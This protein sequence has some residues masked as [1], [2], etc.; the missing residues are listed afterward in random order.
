MKIEDQI[1]VDR[2]ERYLMEEPMKKLR[3]EI[4]ELLSSTKQEQWQDL[5]DRMQHNLSFGTAGLRGKMEAGYNRMNLVSVFRFSYALIQDLSAHNKNVSVVIGYDARQNSRAF[6]DEASLVFTS[7]GIAVH[8]FS[9]CMP[10][11]L[12]AY[13]TKRLNAAAGVMIT[14]SHNPVYD[15]GIKVFEHTSAQATGGLLRR[16]EANMAEVPLRSDFHRT[17]SG[18]TLLKPKVIGDEIVDGYM[19]DI[20]ETRFF[21]EKILSRDVKVAY[22]PLHGVGKKLFL[23]ALL[24][25]GFDNVMVVKEQSEP[26]GSFSTVQFPNPEEENT[27]N[28]A[29]RLAYE[30]ACDLVIANDPDADRLQV[31][32]PDSSGQMKKLSGNEIGSILGYFSILRAKEMGIR[33]LLASSIVSSRMLK[34]MCKAMNAQYIDALTGFSNIVS[35]IQNT[36]F[37]PEHRF[38]FGYEEALGFLMGLIVLDKDGIHAGVRFMEIAGL[39]KSAKKTIWQL[40]DDLYLKF[41][42]FINTSWSWRF[43]GTHSMDLMKSV[44]AKV[45]NIELFRVAQLLDQSEC[46]KFDLLDEQKG[47]YEGLCADV[48]IFEMEGRCRL[49]VRPSGTEPK[50]KFYLELFDQATD[51]QMLSN[52]RSELSGMI[53]KLKNDID[54]VF[55]K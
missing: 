2:C 14:A 23:R 33:P 6:A 51:Q 43:E 4:Q 53:V 5:R 34:T 29:H 32:Y 35:G 39:L 55:G 12:C 3:A 18:N 52:K 27:L 42:I 36:K 49:I 37:D 15:N 19:R 10:T 38:V 25:E 46:K 45:R 48:V 26:D 1:I 21:P 50:I 11:P 8:V 40:L 9:T 16:I 47:S 41:G 24:E 54:R 44:M 13:A 22:T 30:H 7:M 31:S 28:L 17:I 20:K